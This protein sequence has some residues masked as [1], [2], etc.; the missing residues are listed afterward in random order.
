M[1]L[2]KR[3]FL[4]LAVNFLIIVTITVLF[5][6]LGIR[7]FLSEYGIDLPALIIF[8]LILGMGGAF[9]S[10][11]TSRMVAKWTMGVKVIDP[12]TSNPEERRLLQMVR[13]LCDE[14]NL[15]VMP[16]VGFYESSELN[17]FATGPTKARSLLAVSTGLVNQ[18]DDAETK[19]VLGHEV[20]HIA[21]GDM[22][23]M[24]L[25]QGIVNAFSIFLSRVIAFVVAQ[26]LRERGQGGLSNVV[27]F[28]V[29]LMLQ[30]IFLILGSIVVAWFSR[31]REYRADLGGAKFAGRDNMINALKVLERTYENVGDK[32]QA[33]ISNL[34]ISGKGY[35]IF[36]LFATHPPLKDRIERLSKM[37]IS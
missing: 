17:A 31:Y 8:S 36:R 37:A 15:S 6:I 24:T 13:Q 22:V 28:A 33:S 3:I 30:I 23:T 9:I 4:F 11:A 10:L 5:N 14:A 7:P 20:A 26:V 21:N 16:E 32:R 29:S 27:F 35:G 25:L 12:N 1:A 34:K 2:F 18:M 19:A